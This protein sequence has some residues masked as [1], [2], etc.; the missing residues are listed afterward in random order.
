MD[1]Y[2]QICGEPYDVW[3]LQDMSFS[4]AQD[5]KAGKGCPCCEGKKPKNMSAYQKNVTQLSSVAFDILGDDIDGI[6]AMMEDAEFFGL[7]E[8]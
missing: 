6:A 1:L 4:E 2:C 3:S 7:F 8:E 5:F